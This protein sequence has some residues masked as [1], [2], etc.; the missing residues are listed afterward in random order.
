MS[1]QEQGKVARQFWSQTERGQIGPRELYERQR[2]CL[3]THV[4]PS[5]PTDAR[6]LDIGCADGEF[7]LLFARHVRHVVAFDV[8]E[9][10]I[11]QARAKAREENIDNVEFQVADVFEFTSAEKFDAVSLMG[12]LTTISDDNAAARIVLRAMSMLKP[13]G[14][15][16]L[17]DSVL[18]QGVEARTLLNA[19]YEAKYRPESRYLALICSLG[20]REVG[21]HPLLTMHNFGQTSVLYVFRPLLAAEVPVLPIS[22]LRVACY[23]SMPFHF[24]SLRPLAACFEDSLL[25]LSIDE[26]M[27]WKPQVI[28]VADGWSVE[29]WRDYCDAHQVLLIGMRHGSVTRYGYAEPQYNHADYLCGSVWD[30]EDTLLSDVHPRHGFLLTGNAWVD[31][32]FRLPARP[33]NDVEPTILFA[34]T[35]NP[36]ISAAVYFGDRVVSLIRSVYPRAR[37]IIKPHPAIVQHE[38]SFVVDK[39]LF[40]DLMGQWRAQ[41]AA[42]PLV[43]LVDD[44]QASIADSFAEADILVADRSSLLFEF[45]VLDRPT[46]LYSS[47]AR[48]GHWEYNPDAP[49]NAWRDIGMEFGD[50]QGFLDLLGNAYALHRTHCREA[51]RARVRQLYGDFADGR[52]AERVASAI[53]QAPRL[54]VVIDGRRGEQAA[55]LYEAFDDLLAFKR[56]SVLGGERAG[57]A[58]RWL[59]ERDKAQG[60]DLAYLLI[61]GEVAC[62]P[63]SAHQVSD[64]MAAL[65]KGELDAVLLGDAGARPVAVQSRDRDVW[66]RD[67][68]RAALQHRQGRQLWQLL[69]EHALRRVLGHLPQDID[70]EVFDTLWETLSAE[71]RSV[72]WST[73]QMN[74]VLVSSVLR[75]V[76]ARPARYVAGPRAALQLA[77]AVKGQVVTQAGVEAQISIAAAPDQYDGFPFTTEIWV[78]GRCVGQVLL[79]DASAQRL[80]LPFEP[81]ANGVTDIELRSSASFAGM[82]GLAGPLSLCLAFG[83]PVAQAAPTRAHIHQIFY[84]EETRAM[85]EPGYTPLDNVGQRPDWAEYWPIRNLLMTEELDENAFYGVLSPRFRQK[86][87]LGSQQVL[88]FVDAAPDQ[89][90]VLLFP[91]FFAEGARYEN[92]FIQG[93]VHH[94]NIWPAFVEMA[95]Q[96]APG[97]DLETLVMD[98]QQSQFCNYFIAKPRFWR[99]WFSKAETIFQAAEQARSG[100]WPSAYGTALNDVTSHRDTEG[101]A[102]K[103]FVMERLL[104]L[105]LATESQWQVEVYEGLKPSAANGGVDAQ[106]LLLDQLKTRLREADSI[107]DRAVY[108]GMREALFRASFAPQI[109]EIEAKGGRVPSVAEQIQAALREYPPLHVEPEVASWLAARVPT[110]AQQCLIDGYLESGAAPRFGVLV[111]D[112]EG[113]AERLELTLRSLSPGHNLYRHLDI[114]AL[115]V[116]DLPGTTAPGDKLHILRI[117]DESLPA[118]VDR[119]V[120]EGGFDWFMLVDAG[121]EFTAS[122][123]LIAALDVAEAPGLRAIYGDEVVRSS[124][125]ALQVALRPDMNLDMLLSLPGV[126]AGHW[127]FNRD[128]WLALGGLRADAGRAMEF[129]LILRLIEEKGFEGLGHVSEPWLIRDEVPLVDCAAEQHAIQRHLLARGFEGASVHSRLPGR[130]ELNY[131]VGEG[132]LV[133]IM[134]ATHDGLARVRRCVETILERTTYRNFEVLVLDQGEEEP[135]LQAWL[136]AVEQLDSGLVRIMRVPRELSVVQVRNLAARQ[137]EGELLLWLDAGVAVLEDDWL[138]QL[139]NHACRQEVGAVGAK[140]LASDCT[141]RHGGLV[142][143][144]EGV[145]GRVFKGLPMNAGGYLH[146]LAVDQNHAAVSSKCMMMGRALFLEMG[147]FDESPELLPWADVD[148]CLRLQAAGYLNVWTPRAALLISE[149]PEAVATVEQEEAIYAR[150][151]PL[152]ARDPSYNA[153][154]ALV[155]EAFTVAATSSSWSPLSSCK[156]TPKVL[157]H[158]HGKSAGPR[159]GQPLE[160]L[161]RAGL[162]DGSV[163]QTH[164]TLAELERYAPDSIVL[165][166]QISADQIERM[167]QMSMFSRAFKVF[168]L[169]AYL[170][171]L[172]ALAEFGE[173]M[174]QAVA[175]SLRQGLALVDRLVVS[176]EALADA[177]GD[178][179]RP[180]Q[181]VPSYLDPVQWSGL[182]GGRCVG[183][184]PRVGLLGKDLAPQDLALVE[185]VVKALADDVDWVFVGECPDALR[186]YMV[187]CRA[188]L[189]GHDYPLQLARLDLDLALWPLADGFFNECRDDLPVLELGACGVPVICSELARRQGD[190][191]VTWVRNRREDWFA[192]VRMHLDDLDATAR[193]GDA[194]RSQVLRDRMLEGENLLRWRAGWLPA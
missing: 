170:P 184:K 167:R 41:V 162:V 130:Y 5:L 31:Q 123:L 115:T 138:Q 88:S 71:G 69:P 179:R 100:E 84:S 76:G 166:R 182:A 13:G 57:D 136:E 81:N 188:R 117:D 49:G 129:D 132:A 10:L 21:R 90:D 172:P 65:A 141:V 33:M 174:S 43:E 94:P 189:E 19:Q 74:V 32:V 112:R 72:E 128:A 164:L 17:K 185:E 56:I 147:G 25:S 27:A 137:A 42:D 139:V 7:S 3:L 12:V 63:G 9:K 127:L 150:W 34:P 165:Q 40:R 194:L 126:M 51:Q 145:V 1:N 103:V 85:L 168:E 86:T 187:E 160:A 96:L 101:Y 50:D 67:R 68:L 135:E 118:A 191:R 143:G 55:Q 176:G 156:G 154:L 163:I 52:S 75:I 161:K 120:R 95:R 78:N 37:I 107:E 46:L 158:V 30:I 64:G 140:L 83:G 175:R 105:I 48:V 38:H 39:A 14:H 53:A 24:R 35:Y 134:V 62:C 193:M 89:A 192:A 77:P 148:L 151:L 61:D 47:E 54:H 29:F 23:G 2:E 190:L 45:M 70:D 121:V 15:L 8:G 152:L 125:G 99:H 144:L 79:A 157:A 82:P 108:E 131:G 153:N 20:L 18:L 98:S 142:L 181:V 169:D 28:V 110:Q 113:S 80:V 146:R 109:A 149:T 26:V 111:L 87:G 177:L 102:C 171:G 106:L 11:E 36:E 4:L 124:T 155:G 104:P 44:P 133:S 173:E 178:C 97:V 122:G 114:V 16:I 73:E 6:V 93:L 116:L 159:V 60:S 186:P 59:A 66:V 180:I 119:A 91:V 22:G 183:G 92:V 58:K